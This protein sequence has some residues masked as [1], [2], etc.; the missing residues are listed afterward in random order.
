M[1]MPRRS[2]SLAFVIVDVKGGE[3]TPNIFKLLP[4]VN[5]SSPVFTMFCYHLL[6]APC[7]YAFTAMTYSLRMVSAAQKRQPRLALVKG[8]PCM[9]Y[10]LRSQRPMN[11]EPEFRHVPLQ[12]TQNTAFLAYLVHSRLCAVVCAFQ[13]EAV[14]P[15]VLSLSYAKFAV[16][17]SKG[18]CGT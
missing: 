11:E 18:S 16:L 7:Q 9:G 10:Q 6:I 8:P 2:C 1:A 14:L 13:P 5:S 12:T 4:A 3:D 15:F 17:Y